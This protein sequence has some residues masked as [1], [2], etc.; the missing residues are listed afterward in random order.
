MHCLIAGFA[1]E[2][3]ASIRRT[4]HQQAQSAEQTIHQIKAAT[5]MDLNDDQ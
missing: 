5:E 1:A 3:P 4:Q 2:I